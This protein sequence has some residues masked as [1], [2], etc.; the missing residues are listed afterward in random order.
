MVN[1]DVDSNSASLA[2]LQG[3]AC[4]GLRKLCRDSVWIEPAYSSVDVEDCDG[5]DD[6]CDGVVDEDVPGAPLADN[7]IG[8]WG[9]A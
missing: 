8:V 5:I 6:D 3:V 7:Q 1:E 2:D 9:G 4:I